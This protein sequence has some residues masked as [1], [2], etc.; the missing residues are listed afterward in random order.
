MRNKLTIFID[1][2]FNVIQYS[3]VNNSYWNKTIESFGQF[4]SP[5]NFQFKIQL[6]VYIVLLYVIQFEALELKKKKIKWIN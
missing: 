1:Q 6:Q 3:I 5:I 4:Y 2:L